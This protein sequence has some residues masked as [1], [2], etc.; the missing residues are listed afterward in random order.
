[1]YLLRN[2]AS[3]CI[4]LDVHQLLMISDKTLILLILYCVSP[5]FLRALARTWQFLKFILSVSL[6]TSLQLRMQWMISPWSL[7]NNPSDLSLSSPALLFACSALS[8]FVLALNAILKRIIRYDSGLF[9]LL[10][11]ENE[12][13]Y[14]F[15]LTPMNGSRWWFVDLTFV[16]HFILTRTT[17]MKVFRCIYW[18][19][20]WAIPWF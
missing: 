5:I 6:H 4:S 13:P 12:G 18:F 14:V 15:K 8:W 3:S 10:R 1:M 9:R 7:T 20:C 16:P 17:H 19:W 11:S 2:L